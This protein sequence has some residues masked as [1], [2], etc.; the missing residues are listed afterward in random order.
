MV[1]RFGSNGFFCII[2]FPYEAHGPPSTGQ[3]VLTKMLP[4]KQKYVLPEANPKRGLNSNSHK[5]LSQ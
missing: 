5:T 3:V 4:L 1:P 2:D